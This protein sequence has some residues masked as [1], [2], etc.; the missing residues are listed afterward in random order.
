[1]KL[2]LMILNIM[3]IVHQI[4]NK[5]FFLYI[6]YFLLYIG[7][8]ILLF[9]NLI[10]YCIYLIFVIFISQL[11]NILFTIKENYFLILF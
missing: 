4:N 8:I 3:K 11:I 5:C 10:L 1:M 9:T 7:Y 6:F 2:I